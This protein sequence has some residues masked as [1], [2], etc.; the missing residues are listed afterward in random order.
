M[1]R[2][3]P[4]FVKE[5]CKR[6]TGALQGGASCG[7]QVGSARSCW[8]WSSGHYQLT[9]ALVEGAA[10]PAEGAVFTLEAGVSVVAHFTAS[11]VEGSLE[12]AADFTA[13]AGVAAFTGWALVPL[14]D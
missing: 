9:R 2:H 3:C 10:S 13:L 5:D 1:S 8:R 4:L 6:E 7:E 12:E 11:E 14:P